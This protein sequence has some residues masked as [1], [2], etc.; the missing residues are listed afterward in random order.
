[1]SLQTTQAS[2]NSNNP[3]FIAVYSNW[4]KSVWVPAQLEGISAYPADIIVIGFGLGGET[5]EILG[6]V[7]ERE[8]HPNKIANKNLSKE[9]GDAIYYWAR[10]VSFF[11]WDAT[12]LFSKADLEPTSITHA[13]LSLSVA[14][15][16]VQEP[17]KKYVRD[18][19]LDSE[20]LEQGLILYAKAWR[21]LSRALGFDY[22]HLF[23]E[24]HEKVEGRVA[25]GTQRGSGNNR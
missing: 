12:T 11:E 17:C 15:G 20:K 19:S 8:L 18:G 6:E 13:A 3:D 25:R 2:K 4:T 10:F 14:A 7:L 23:L 9:M 5:S 21:E 16:L 1:M 22:L 24:N